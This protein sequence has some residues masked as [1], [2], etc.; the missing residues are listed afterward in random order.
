MSKKKDEKIS[1]YRQWK[2]D[3]LNDDDDAEISEIYSLPKRSN[4]FEKFIAQRPTSMPP[5]ILIPIQSS[6][7][8][9]II[10][11]T[12]DH[13]EEIS[14]KTKVFPNSLVQQSRLLSSVPIQSQRS[15]SSRATRSN[16]KPRERRPRQRK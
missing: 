3:D 12:N 8:E 10:D 11:L 15:R 14:T 13:G 2:L 4:A 9:D 7:M 1:T 6:P 16:R 5:P